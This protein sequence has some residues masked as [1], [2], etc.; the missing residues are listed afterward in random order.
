M[1]KNNKIFLDI[2]VVVDFIESSRS[3]HQKAVELIQYLTINDYA[4]H[5][6]EDM[7]TTIYYI[8][9]NKKGV[10]NF[11][12]NIVDDWRI[13]SFGQQVIKTGI[14]LSLKH[15]LDLEDVLQC[16][17]AKENNCAVFITNDNKFCDCG[18]PVQQVGEFLQSSHSHY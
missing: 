17:C 11:L 3:R 15:G 6:S 1:K 13:L 14:D 2:N 12:R 9:K 8:A 7:L 16:L 5:I 10:L 4:I 18:L